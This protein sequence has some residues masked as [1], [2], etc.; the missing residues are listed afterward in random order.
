[1]DFIIT[2]S[3]LSLFALFLVLF[4]YFSS[5]E[6]FYNL[7]DSS[8]NSIWSLNSFGPIASDCYSLS[9]NN[10]LKSSNCGLCVNK[11]NNNLSC[12]PGDVHGPLFHNNCNKWIYNDFDDKKIF[13]NA[14]FHKSNNK[15]SNFS[16]VT[17]LVD[18][19]NKSY[20]DY[21]I[22]YPS[23]KNIFNL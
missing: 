3:L 2:F 16:P 18:P 9:N 13:G 8:E 23:S 1:M 4:Y 10:C 6:S 14:N 7:P 11:F 12:L 5:V 21:Q 15:F 22:V 17:K 20:S 19:W